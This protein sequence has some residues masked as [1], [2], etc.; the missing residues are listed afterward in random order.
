MGRIF[1]NAISSTGRALTQKR[2]IQ[3]A[4]YHRITTVKHA[5]FRQK[6]G[7]EHI[8][9]PLPERLGTWK[10][11][12]GST[13]FM[14]AESL[15]AAAVLG[16][17]IVVTTHALLTANRW[18][19]ASRVLTGA[20]AIVQRN[21]DTALTTTFTQASEPAILMTTP[22]AGQ[23]WDDDGGADNTVQIAVQDNGGIILATGVLTRTVLSI[24]NPD[25]AVVR[26]VTFSLNYTY[27]GRNTSI[28]MTTIRSRDD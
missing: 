6:P 8:G 24:A 16:L 28:G 27:L 25:N 7:T 22:I 19:A 9:V 15:V 14:L 18:A 10:R 3:N 2:G 5:K 12:R 11:I 21:I 26:Q 13:A 17:I 20:R 23:V 4:N 1:W